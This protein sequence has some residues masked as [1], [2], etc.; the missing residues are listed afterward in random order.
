MAFMASVRLE[1]GVSLLVDTGSPG[2]ICGSEWSAEM[3][4]ESQKMGDYP[5]YVK[6]AYPAK[7]SGIGTGVH[8][9]S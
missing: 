3:A 7:C 4:V 1:H 9:A 2:N 5:R 6:M 8:E